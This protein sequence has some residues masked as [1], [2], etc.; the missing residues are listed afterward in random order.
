MTPLPP[1]KERLL[2]IVGALIGIAIIGLV[3]AVIA[4]GAFSTPPQKESPPVNITP[5]PPS[6]ISVITPPS[7]GLGTLVPVTIE[8][9]DFSYGPSPSIWLA[10][11]GERDVS[12]TDVAVVSPTL[13]K[14]TFPLTASSMS[15]G[16][17]DVFLKNVNEQYGSKIGVFT[18]TNEISPPLKWNWS[19][20]GWG[21]WQ[22]AALC[23]GTTRKET[24]SCS[25]YGPFMEN[26]FGVQGSSVT[27]DRVQTESSVWKTFTA[28]SGTRWNTLTFNGLLSSSK[29]PRAR[30]MAVE[31]NGERIF[32]ANATQTPPGNGQAFTI[33]QSFNPANSVT[34]MISGGQDPTWGT[35]M[36]TMQFDTL[37]LS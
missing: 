16:Q 6:I 1:N 37:T 23:K 5:A 7:G 3:L 36:F 22:H 32:Y 20:D 4:M 33:T 11:Q 14:C 25:E 19:A 26:G 9:K 35:T 34:V 31:V 17:W 2:K 29:L 30:W 13:I 24:G 27:Y 18:V 21:D 8:G 28:P 15:A 10:K 12:A